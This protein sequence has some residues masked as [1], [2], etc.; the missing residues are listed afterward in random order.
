M[1]T[2]DTGNSRPCPQRA[3]HVHLLG[4]MPATG[5]QERQWLVQHGDRF[6]QL[7]ELPYRV[8]DLA[9][10]RRTIGE[11]ATELTLMT[12]WAVEAGDV[13][14]MVEKLRAQGL[15][16]G[17]DSSTGGGHASERSPLQMS[18]HMKLLP[19]RALERVTDIFKHLYA[20]W[21][22]IVIGAVIAVAHWWLYVDLGVTRGVESMLYKPG[23]LL[24]IVALGIAAGLFHEIGHASALKYGG[25]HPRAI[26]FG[27][28]LVYPAFYS[29]VTDAY[30][31]ERA[32]RIRTDLG[33]I[34]FH[35]IFAAL[36]IA[37]ACFTG[38]TFLAVAALV[39]NIEAVRQFIPFV[40]LDGYWLLADLTG[41]PDLFSQALPFVR[42]LAPKGFSGG[43]LPALKPW[44]R[45]VFAAYLLITIPVLVYAFV[46]ML[47][48]LPELVEH[49]RRALL[50][51]FELIRGQAPPATK[52]LSATQM[53]LLPVPLAATAYF[54]YSLSLKP[55]TQLAKRVAAVGDRHISPRLVR[56]A[57]APACV[58]IVLITATAPGWPQR[59][60]HAVEVLAGARAR[61]EQMHSLEADVH[62]AIGADEFTGHIALS[63]PNLA[64]VD[65][66]G[67]ESVGAFNVI[68][69]GT[70]TYV[71]FPESSQYTVARTA[72]DGRNINAFLVDHVRMF[73]VPDRVTRIAPSEKAR[74][75]GMQ[76][77]G[78]ELVD[79]VEI[80]PANSAGARWSYF[81]SSDG[82][83]RR[84]VSSTNRTGR[85]EVRW[86]Q[87][88]NIE[89]DLP[90]AE[91]LFSWEPEGQRLSIANLGVDLS[92]SQPAK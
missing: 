62:G 7:S 82:L 35:L 11:I 21:L 52:L 36:L 49:T 28:Y 61:F 31:L 43:R 18:M 55:L 83:V 63:R 88:D 70:S 17:G 41:I 33:G 60:N 46:M 2:N 56:W 57:A 87:L 71:T 37:I 76:Q 74:F 25:G 69:D 34:Y 3:S 22:L 64:R 50:F 20:P 12:E 92:T 32:A 15:M 23:G 86:V 75:A 67:T 78:D 85:N 10:G 16:A 51:H 38:S 91:R 59:Q 40:R 89:T 39:F 1:K 5:Y 13:G 72:A 66:N 65:I 30:R 42:R 58:C 47:L 27:L 44:V 53:L 81:V 26:G 90:V 4:E 77:L 19:Q 29:D 73:F 54:L 6:L 48:Y 24:A 14:R 80:A 84:V 68:A 9:D 79:V 8:L 45:N